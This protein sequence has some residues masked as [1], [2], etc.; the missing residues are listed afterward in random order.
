MLQTALAGA[1]EELE[2]ADLE[3]ADVAADVPAAPAAAAGGDVDKSK[4]KRKAKSDDDNGASGS[5]DVPASPQV[6]LPRKH[7]VRLHKHAPN[8]LSLCLGYLLLLASQVWLQLGRMYQHDAFKL[9]HS[10]QQA[11]ASLF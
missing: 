5:K 2:D 6:C 7:I 3:V 11:L 9:V 8:C 1:E 10:E 4:K